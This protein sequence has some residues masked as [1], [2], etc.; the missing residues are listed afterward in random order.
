MQIRYAGFTMEQVLPLIL[1]ILLIFLLPMIMRRNGWDFDDFMRALVGGLWKKG[2]YDPKA[3]EKAKAKKRE[4][5]L[6]NGGKGEMMELLSSLITFARRHDFGIVYPGTL[7]Y[8]SEVATLLALLVTKSEVVGINCFGY[9]G[10]ITAG[11]GDA[12]WKQHMNEQDIMIKSPVVLCRKQQRL[13]RQAMDAAGMK[14]VS[15]RVAGVFTNHHVT[16]AIG[17]G[18]GL[19]TTESLIEELKVQASAEEERIPD[20]QKVAEQLAAVTKKIQPGKR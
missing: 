4:P 9:G 3:D 14:D 18:Y 20:P 12:D 16:L 13:C 8:K 1:A 19:Y 11:K 6:S 7:E 5:H 15:V 2:K 17:N 10:T